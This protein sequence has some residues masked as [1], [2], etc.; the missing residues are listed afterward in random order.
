LQY[1]N[2]YENQKNKLEKF[3]EIIKSQGSEETEKNRREGN[4]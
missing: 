2:R 3:K 1:E 4:N